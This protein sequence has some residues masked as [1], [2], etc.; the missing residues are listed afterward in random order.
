[1]SY[2]STNAFAKILMG[3]LPCIKICDDAKT[4]A[5][6]DIMPQAD[7]HVL[8]VTKEPATTIF[9]LSDEGLAACI[10][11][12]RRVALAVKTALDAPGLMIV[13][14]NGTAAGQT[15]PH[16]HFHVIPR[17]D[18][19]PLRTHALTREDTAKLRGL[20]DRIGLP[21]RFAGK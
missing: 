14:L 19:A 9:D 11:M 7:G 12:T 3:E 8:M 4:L 18:E 16:V 10:K 6:M 2:D 15:V 20:A 17:S 21:G 13:Q 1:M 5:F